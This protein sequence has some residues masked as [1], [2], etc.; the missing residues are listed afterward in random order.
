MVQWSDYV[1]LICDRW[2]QRWKDS[3]TL[4]HNKAEAL[5]HIIK[6]SMLDKQ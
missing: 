6:H 3:E 5:L 2:K 1:T 4:L